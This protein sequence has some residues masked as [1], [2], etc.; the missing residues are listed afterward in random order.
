MAKH[1]MDVTTFVGKLLEQDDVDALR[2]GVRILAQLVM[3]REVSAQIGAEPYER[4]EDRLAYRNGYRTRTWDTRVGTIELKIPKVTRG[5]YFPS[6]LD[7]RRRAEKALYSVIVEAYVKG[8]S[9]RKVDDLVKALGIDG[10]SKSEVSRICKLLDEEVEAFRSR[11]IEG[12]IPYLWLDATFHKVRVNERVCSLATVVAVGVTSSGERTVLGVDAGP[13]EDHV[14]WTQFLR[15]LVKR[16]LTGVQLVISD[17]HEGLVQAIAKVLHGAQWQRCRVHFMR[18]LLSTVPKD[19]QPT[20]AV[21]VKMIFIEPDHA[22]ALTQLRKVAG[23]LEHR[24]PRAAELLE[25]TAEE[26]LAHLHFPLE[27][28][29]RLHST[30]PLERLHKEIK[31]RT[32]VVGIF[33][34]RA[35]LLRLVGALMAEQDDEWQVADRRYF[36]TASMEQIGKLEGGE[37]QK[38]LLAAIA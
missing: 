30:N 5:S 11:P 22:S 36:S 4:T 26:L 17:A 23:T 2:E 32:H 38:E 33:P 27:H 9:T 18:N 3:E 19:A 12:A 28:R 15:S 14:F 7:P 35:S 34:N 8:I 20:V 6:L 25:E 21:L 37:I 16:G 31:R 10:I 29:R 1:R 13:S 24:F